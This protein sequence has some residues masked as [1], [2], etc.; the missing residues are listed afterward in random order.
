MP[1]DERRAVFHA[2]APL[3]HRLEEI[4]G[5]PQRDDGHAEQR[6]ERNRDVGQPPPSGHG[7][8]QRAEHESTSG[9]FDG[10]LRT[11]CRR[12][13]PAARRAAGVVLR[14]IARHDREHQQ[15][16]RGA[17]ARF[18]N[19]HHRPNRQPQVERREHRGRREPERVGTAAPPHQRQAGERNERS[20]DR[21]VKRGYRPRDVTQPWRRGE[22]KRRQRGGG[23][24]RDARYPEPARGGEL[25]QLDERADEQELG[26][27]KEEDRRREPD[28][29]DSEG[30]ERG[31]AQDAR[32]LAPSASGDGLI[33][34]YRRS[35]FW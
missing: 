19:R 26:D 7:H 10:F 22:T 18:A 17:A 34:P 23:S 16:Q 30:Q 9:P 25:R 5:D 21:G 6:P 20:H 2:G 14:D 27:G 32:H 28:D 33:P 11:D 24:G 8:R 1:G 29:G 3:E 31:A 13:P 4:A 15:E 12:Q 35:R